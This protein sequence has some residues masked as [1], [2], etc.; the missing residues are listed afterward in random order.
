[1]MAAPPP[2]KPAWIENFYKNWPVMLACSGLVWAAIT[3]DIAHEMGLVIIQ[4]YG[5]DYVRGVEKDQARVNILQADNTTK[6][7]ALME[8]MERRITRLEDKI[9]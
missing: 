9:K 1:M 6:I 7:V 8:A 3:R 5:S 2:P 4:K